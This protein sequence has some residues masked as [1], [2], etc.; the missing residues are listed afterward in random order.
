MSNEPQQYT[1]AIV[2]IVHLSTTP[3][4]KELEHITAQNKAMI[5]KTLLLAAKKQLPVIYA[6][7]VNQKG[8][9]TI[10]EVSKEIPK[11]PRLIKLNQFE[12]L[13]FSPDDIRGLLK[14]EQIRPTEVTILGQLRDFCV[15]EAAIATKHAF[16][17]TK[18]TIM[19]GKGTIMTP[20][21]KKGRQIYREKMWAN[22]IRGTKRL[23]RTP[24][25][26]K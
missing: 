23:K 22:S 3:F 6:P 24:L 8:E 20:W 21:E 7:V 26:T 11:M 14:R 2:F 17:K 9:D 13:S 4:R 1:G 10:T 16:P 19:E 12:P 5:K 18:V 15:L 25:N